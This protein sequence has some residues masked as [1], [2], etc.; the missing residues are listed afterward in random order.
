ML[1]S[2]AS[3]CR[4]LSAT[5]SASLLNRQPGSRPHIYRN[6]KGIRQGYVLANLRL[7]PFA[8]YTGT[9]APC[10]VGWHGT[11]VVMEL[12]WRMGDCIYMALMA[13]IDKDTHLT[14]IKVIAISPT[15]GQGC[16]FKTIQKYCSSISCYHYNETSA[17]EYSFTNA[18]HF[19][20]LG[21]QLYVVPYP[22]QARD[23]RLHKTVLK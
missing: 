7:S 11:E 12:R 9:F 19:H 13:V 20:P 4:A 16:R 18:V 17:Y 1:S 5:N 10:S 6:Q 22:T 3:S 14:M 15:L 8:G 23:R 21:A 2:R